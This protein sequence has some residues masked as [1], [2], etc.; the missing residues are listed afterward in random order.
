MELV[1]EDTCRC[2]EEDK[3]EDDQVSDWVML[4]RLRLRLCLQLDRFRLFLHLRHE[5]EG[6]VPRISRRR[7]HDI[8][9]LREAIL[10]FWFS[11]GIRSGLFPLG[12]TLRSLL[13]LGLSLSAPALRLLFL[14]M[15][16]MLLVCHCY[17][18][19]S[20]VP[21]RRTILSSAFPVRSFLSLPAGPAAP[22][23]P[24]GSS[25]V[26]QREL[27]HAVLGRDIHTGRIHA[28]ES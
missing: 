23:K 18:S 3:K 24:G 4:L 12:G 21:A 15:A 10:V 7:I 25:C 26:G 13:F 14:E 16:C 27:C 6:V 5:V 1:A 22:A 20:L 9:Y 17:H 19:T 11:F 2:N 28:H 8:G